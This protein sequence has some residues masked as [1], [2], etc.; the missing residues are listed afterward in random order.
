MPHKGLRKPGYGALGDEVTDQGPLTWQAKLKLW[1]L[2][3]AWGS[4]DQ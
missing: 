4:F 3:E 2:G 1:D